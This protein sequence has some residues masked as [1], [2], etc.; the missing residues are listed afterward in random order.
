LYTILF[1]IALFSF[2][3]KGR[4][5]NP[6]LTTPVREPDCHD[7]TADFAK[8]K[9]SLLIIAVTRIFKDNKGLGGMSV[10]L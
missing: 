5:E 1:F 4:S 6:D 10:D 2:P 7:L 9:I 8:A 3:P